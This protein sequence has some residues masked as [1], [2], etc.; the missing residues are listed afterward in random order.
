MGCPVSD[1]G[2]PEDPDSLNLVDVHLRSKRPI[3]ALV[4]AALFPESGSIR[5]WSA[6]PRKERKIQTDSRL[7][8]S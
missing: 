6:L 4:G 3:G 1:G 7:G 5:I 8:S 2:G